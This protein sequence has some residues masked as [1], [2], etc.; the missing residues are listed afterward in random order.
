MIGDLI[1]IRLEFTPG[2]GVKQ[3]VVGIDTLKLKRRWY[4]PKP[5]LADLRLSSRGAAALAVGAVSVA[6]SWHKGYAVLIGVAAVGVAISG[7]AAASLRPIP[8]SFPG[9]R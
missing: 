6:V 7:R 8:R 9:A 5:E 4:H 1:S 2:G 3:M